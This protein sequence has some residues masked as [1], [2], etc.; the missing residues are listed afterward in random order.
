MRT[1]SLGDKISKGAFILKFFI[2]LFVILL[3]PAEGFSVNFSIT[4]VRIFFEGN[5]KTDILTIK[6][7][8]SK[9]A[10][11]QISAVAWTQDEKSDN[12]YLPTGDILFFPKLVDIKPGEEKIIRIGNK[13]PRGDTEKTYR[14][15]I[16]EIPDNTQMETTSVKILMKVG[17]PIFIFR[18]KTTASGVIEKMEFHKAVSEWMSKMM[19]IYILS[20]RR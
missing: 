3:F 7:E 10:A 19:A 14:L 1:T 12:V 8:S 6:N 11:L 18:L 2:C 16:E 15:F 13:V 5:K 4:P 9:N 20:L 17:V